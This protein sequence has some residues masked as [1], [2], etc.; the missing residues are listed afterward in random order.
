MFIDLSNPT[1]AA[2][3]S[4]IKND[5]TIVKINSSTRLSPIKIPEVVRHFDIEPRNLVRSPIFWT[6]IVWLVSILM[7]KESRAHEQ[8]FLGIAL[9]LLV[10]SSLILLA[11]LRHLLLPSPAGLQIRFHSFT[12]FLLW[13]AALIPPVSIGTSWL[14]LTTDDSIATEFGFRKLESFVY[15]LLFLHVAN[16][17]AYLLGILAY[18][19]QLFQDHWYIPL[20]VAAT[21]GLLIP[22]GFLILLNT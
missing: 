6:A 4:E 21:I 10:I 2:P 11:G 13:A 16:S 8:I 19:I 14:F 22:F 17:V 3:S 1:R 18:L 9:G 7:I 5:P 20:S 12:R 15:T